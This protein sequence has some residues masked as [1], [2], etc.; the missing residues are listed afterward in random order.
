[1]PISVVPALYC[2]ITTMNW[3]SA[4]VSSTSIKKPIKGSMI[5]CSNCDTP[6]A[7]LAMLNL[8]NATNIHPQESK[9]TSIPEVEA[10]AR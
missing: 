4:R 9:D 3:P 1:M 10:I 6:K 8:V 2:P 5:L 7:M